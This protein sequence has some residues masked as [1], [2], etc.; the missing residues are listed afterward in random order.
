MRRSVL[1][2]ALVAAVAPWALA[3][4]D[5]PAAA[6][7]P[8]PP[9]VPAGP[10]KQVQIQVWISETGEEGLRELGADLTFTRFV[11]G[12]ETSGSVQ[13]ISTSVFDP[14]NAPFQVTLPV[15][16]QTLFNA[17][18]R[19][20]QAG[21]LS[22]ALQA[23]EG[24]GMTFTILPNEYGTVDGVFRAVEQ[25][26]DIDLISKPE[27]LVVDEGTASIHAGSEIPY[28]D[29]KF[30]KGRP[31]A[32]VT[33]R[34]VGVN[35][36]L[37]PMIRPDNMVQLNITKLEVSDIARLDTIRGIDLPVFSK[38]GQ[39]GKVIV[40]NGQTLVIGGLS[41]R[42]IRKTETRVPLVGKV[43]VLGIPFRGRRSEASTTHLLIFV[44]PTVI[45]IANLEQASVDAL[46][47][48][49]KGTEKWHHEEDIKDEIQLLEDDL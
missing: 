45:D 33:W 18:L 5:A 42:V 31:Q 4:E 6:P 17:P 28:Q 16:D 36:D 39:T 1:L 35:L 48:W 25:K 24:V 21:N 14:Q 13:Q 15:P 46:E 41:S 22:N 38:R 12:R 23:Q 7:A 26:S 27:L 30:E 40:P 44:S 37:S 47:F 32:K 8:A 2:V 29:V 10:P 43:P 34:E 19:P 49:R 11:R 20:D 9:P 3:Q